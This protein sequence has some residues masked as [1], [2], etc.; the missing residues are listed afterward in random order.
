M[1]SY[2][3]E[4]P[5][6]K[7]KWQFSMLPHD[8]TELLKYWNIWQSSKSS[9]R[10]YSPKFGSVFHSVIFFCQFLVKYHGDIR[11]FI[12]VVFPLVFLSYFS[13]KVLLSIELLFVILFVWSPIFHIIYFIFFSFR[14]G[15]K[16]LDWVQFFYF[17]E[18]DFPIHSMA[19]IILIKVINYE[20]NNTKGTTWRNTSANVFFI[21]SSK[22]H[23]SGIIKD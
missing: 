1:Y 15:S 5:L 12:S 10:F 4:F 14:L 16:L 13:C 22:G 9:C 19:T 7:Q 18:K 8:A 2:I 20:C 6:C 11:V 23:T 17:R 21:M 3:R